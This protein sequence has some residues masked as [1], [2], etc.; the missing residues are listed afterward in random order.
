MQFFIINP[1]YFYGSEY[2]ELKFSLKNQQRSLKICIS[3]WDSK[4]S[5]ENS[6]TTDLECKSTLEEAQPL[7]FYQTS[8][9]SGYSR[10]DCPPIYIG[11]Y[12][13][14]DSQPIQSDCFESN[15]T[16]FDQI[17]YEFSHQGA[18]GSGF[19]KYLN[20]STLAF[21]ILISIYQS[22]RSYI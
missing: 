4:P 15:C 21:A 5:S 20:L 10:E 22:Y 14:K 17:Q 12:G 2:L 7:I 16:N 19:L 18:N 3:R 11:V 6:K 9:C 8:P 1:V 13:L